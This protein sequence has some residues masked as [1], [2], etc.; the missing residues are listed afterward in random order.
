MQFQNDN[1]FKSTNDTPNYFYKSPPSG[2]VSINDF[3]IIAYERLQILYA[4]EIN[5]FRFGKYSTAYYDALDN[6]IRKIRKDLTIKYVHLQK[7]SEDLR[8]HLSHFILRLCFCKT[9]DQRKWFIS[10]EVEY[11]KYKLNFHDKISNSQYMKSIMEHENLNYIPLTLEE[12]EFLLKNLINSTPKSLNNKLKDKDTDILKVPFIEIPELIRKRRVYINKGWAYVP[13]YELIHIIIRRFRIY[14][15]YILTYTRNYISK[16]KDKRLL[17]LIEGGEQMYNGAADN[18][19]YQQKT[20]SGDNLTSN[21]IEKISESFPLCMLNLHKNLLKDHKLKHWGRMQYGLFLKG[22]G[23]PMSEA[24]KFW[25]NEFI[26]VI[27]LENFQKQYSY[28]VRHMYGKE[29]KK[30]DYTPYN[31]IKVIMGATPGPQDFHGCPFKHMD[32]SVLRQN[33]KYETNPFQRS[34]FNKI[35][36]T[37][38]EEIVSLAQSSHFQIA[39]SRH[40][41]YKHNITMEKAPAINHPNQY[42][43]ESQKILVVQIS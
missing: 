27:S 24:L 11:L 36:D 8:D 37:Q 3:N 13:K 18:G 28:N 7:F 10:N 35:S 9:E 20:I 40:F 39:C 33:I 31:C 41:A 34:K 30:A 38:I 1:E 42:F 14:L 22:L 5:G 17:S 16:I 21:D 43:E 2:L 23:L 6:E 26:K 29:G 15:S 12:K 19:K 25:Q 32:V 4:I